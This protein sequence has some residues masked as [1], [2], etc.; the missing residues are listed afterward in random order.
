MLYLLFYLFC[1]GVGINRGSNLFVTRVTH[2]FQF[3]RHGHVEGG[4]DCGVVKGE[5]RNG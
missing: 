2:C 3:E 5:E 4:L 1:I